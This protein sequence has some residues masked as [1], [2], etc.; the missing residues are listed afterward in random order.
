MIRLYLIR[1]GESAGNI[2]KHLGVADDSPLTESGIA[3]AEA[4]A[5][6][7][8]GCKIDALFSSPAR[9]ALATAGYIARHHRHLICR[10]DSR[11]KELDYGRWSGLTF[12]RISRNDPELCRKWLA[13]PLSFT[14]PGG[15]NC[16][17]AIARAGSFLCDLWQEHDQSQ[18]P[19]PSREH[20][21]EHSRSVAVVSH[22]GLLRALITRLLDMPPQLILRL[23][24]AHG[25][26]SVINW[27]G[28]GNSVIE[29]L[30]DTRHLPLPGDTDG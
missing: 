17:D 9:R 12:E 26:I 11:L 16:L 25:S 20:G 21:R 6:R 1:H 2:Q 23:S 29:T 10:S 3:Q 27:F 8:A 24:I 22:G 15:E 14:P 28:E 18:L 30:N 5:E 19:Q 7:L 13:E 4:V